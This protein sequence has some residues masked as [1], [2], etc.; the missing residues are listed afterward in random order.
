M[1]GR[2]SFQLKTHGH[3]GSSHRGLS[4]REVMELIGPL[5]RATWLGGGF[6]HRHG[7]GF[8]RDLVQTAVDGTAPGSVTLEVVL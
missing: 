4:A 6:H 5:A 1:F 3:I 2:R 8:G 7:Y